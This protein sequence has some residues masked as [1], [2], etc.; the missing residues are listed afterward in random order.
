MYQ[1][2]LKDAI[3]HYVKAKLGGYTSIFDDWATP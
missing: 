2:A 3:T 1:Y